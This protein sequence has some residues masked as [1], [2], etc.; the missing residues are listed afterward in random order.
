MDTVFQH[1]SQKHIYTVLKIKI[2]L[3]SWHIAL[4]FEKQI[5]YVFLRWVGTLLG[6]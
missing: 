3:L 4:F 5:N 2:K 1:G 6:K